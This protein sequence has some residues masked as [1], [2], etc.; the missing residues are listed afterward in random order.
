MID[1]DEL[2]DAAEQALITPE[3][4]LKALRQLDT[5]LHVI[6]RDDFY[7]YQKYIEDAEN[8]DI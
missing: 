4:M 5:L 6:Y 8:Q 2:A 7:K 1:L 3:M